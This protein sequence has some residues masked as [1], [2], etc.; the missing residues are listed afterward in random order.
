MIMTI[1]MSLGFSR[2]SKIIVIAI[3]M[4]NHCI[5]ALTL[6]GESIITVALS[7]AHDTITS[8]G[9]TSEK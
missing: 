2:L 6:C 5:N 3:S 9:E 7:L 4:T 8:K 1:G